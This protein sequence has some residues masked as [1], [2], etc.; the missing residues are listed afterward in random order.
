MKD[1]KVIFMGTPD[2][3]VP[4]LEELIKKCTVI[5]VVTQPDKEVGRKK[6]L[7]PSPIKEVALKNN[8]KVLQPVKIKEEYQDIIDLNPDIIITCAYG[9][10]VPEVILNAPKYGCINVH[11]SLLPKLRGGAPIHKAIINGYKKTGITIMYMDKGMDTG[12]MISKKEVDITDFDTAETLHDKLQKASVPLLME[13]LPSIINGTNKRE[14]QNNDE[15][16]YAY[17]V[18]REDEHVNF[19]DTSLNVYNKIRGLNSWPG[20]YATLD[21][22]NIKLWVSKISDNVYDKKPGTIVNLNKDGMEVVT[23]DKSILITELQL[24]GKKK[25]NIKDFINGNKKEDYLNKCFK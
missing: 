20:A 22:K 17:N 3:C 8:I 1:L 16:T 12:D 18:S 14:K 9:Q 6:V 19:N 23:K 13:T 5:A 4:I 24:P 2:F 10:I 15:A 7:T 25:M 11:A 21:D